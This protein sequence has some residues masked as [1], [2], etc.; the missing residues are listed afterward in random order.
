MTAPTRRLFLPKWGTQRRLEALMANGWPVAELESL[1]RSAE[2]VRRMR[3]RDSVEQRTAERV[4][5]LYEQLW[6][7]PPPESTASLRIRRRAE[8]LGWPRPM[9][10]DDDW[11]DLPPDELEAQLAR[12][13]ALMEKADLCSAHL[14]RIRYGDRSPLSVAASREYMRRQKA[15]KRELERKRD[16]ERRAARRRERERLA[17]A[18]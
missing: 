15:R 16:R 6:N 12:E 14:S 2:L 17:Q 9:E 11:I 13:V 5:R 7:V 3:A 18:A 1:L 8:R 10:W 4:K